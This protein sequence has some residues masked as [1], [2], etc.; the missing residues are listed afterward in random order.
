M[1][2]LYIRHD[3][4]AYKS[5]IRKVWIY[6][7]ADYEKLNENINLF[8]W[9]LFLQSFN[10][11]NVAAKAFGDKFVHLCIPN[12]TVTN[13]DNDRPWYDSKIRRESRK[14]DRLKRKASKTNTYSVWTKYKE[15]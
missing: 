8:N 15:M 6:K 4:K 2:Y 10:D 5:Y 9:E 7:E 1:S 12:R 13:R 3:F 11:V 14:R